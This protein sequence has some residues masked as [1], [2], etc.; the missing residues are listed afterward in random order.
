M[1]DPGSA[2]VLGLVCGLLGSLVYSRERRERTDQ[3]RLALLSETFAHG[4]AT[5][6]ATAQLWAD[7]EPEVEEEE[8]PEPTQA[9]PAVPVWLAQGDGWR[10]LCASTDVRLR[11]ENGTV[12]GVEIRP[13]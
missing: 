2:F 10:I 12:T 3:Q 1:T 13:R 7:D 8:E 9:A 6:N 11:L 5:A 4:A